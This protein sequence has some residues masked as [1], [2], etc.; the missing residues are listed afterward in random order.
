MTRRTRR[1][2]AVGLALAGVGFAASYGYAPGLV[3]ASIRRGAATLGGRLDPGLAL[4]I[5]GATTGVLGL[6][7]AWIGQRD[8][9]GSLSTP[10]DAAPKRRTAVAGG[11]LTAHYDRMATGDGA[12]DADPLRERLR[13][14]VVE[15]YRR[16]RGVEGASAVVDEGAWT[17][18][19]YAA[20][21]LSTTAAVDYP[22]YHRLYAWLYPAR[23]YERRVNR[24]LRAVERTCERRVT[25]YDAPTRAAGGWRRRLRAALEGSS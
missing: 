16:E 22:W 11:D 9:A 18:D 6:L 5:V 2:V 13:D 8:D 20:A 17:D 12:A 1:R 4:L 14:A 7:Y 24:T 19:R 23:A 3:P 15:A 21:F 10:A 25:G